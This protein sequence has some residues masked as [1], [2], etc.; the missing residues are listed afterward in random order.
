LILLQFVDP[1]RV[2]LAALL[3]FRQLLDQLILRHRLT[4]SPDT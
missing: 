1:V 4:A 3:R 2:A